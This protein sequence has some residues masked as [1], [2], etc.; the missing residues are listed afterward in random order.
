MSKL[1]ASISVLTALA[2]ITAACTSDGERSG[3]TP[4]S[5][6]PAPVTT[7]TLAVTTTTEA[8]PCEEFVFCVLYEIDPDAAWSDGTPVSAADLQH[9]L[10]MITDPVTGAPDQ[11][12]YRLIEEIVP[13]GDGTVL[14]GFSEVFAP[15]RTLFEFVLPAHAEESFGTEGAPVTGPFVLDEWVEGDRIVLRRNP[16]YWASSDPVSEAPL[17][18]VE[19]IVFVFPESVRDQL[20]GLESG[21]IDVIEPRP[22]EWMIPELESMDDVTYDVVPGEFWEHIDFNHDDP[23]LGQDWVREAISLAIDREEILDA[24]VR[25]IDPDAQPLDSAIWMRNSVNYQ[26]NYD[27]LHDPEAAESLLKERFCELAAD[28]VYECQGRRMSFTWATTV[29]DEYR[30]SIFEIVSNS[31]EQIGIEVVLDQRTPSELFSSNVFFGGPSIWQIISFSWKG[32]ADPFRAN[33]TFF[34]TG[35]APSGFGTLN[36][37]R[38]CNPEVESLIRSTQTLVDPAA[39]HGAYHQADIAYLAD[40]AIVPLF[41]K[42]EL[43]AFNSAL[44]GLIPNISGSTNLWNV[45]AWQGQETVVVAL[46]GEPSSLDPLRPDGDSARVV[47]TAMLHGLLGVDPSLDFVP[48]LVEQAEARLGGAGK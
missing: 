27:Q 35:D 11:V 8:D 21:D 1:R 38:Y 13:L 44:S 30:N 16:A 24:T 25:A 33:S 23:L 48:V 19:E 15:W 45:A 17:G 10:D 3:S 26:D 9:T 12:G 29:G 18:D 7:T 5:P 28:G 41:Q 2:I 39:R 37:N 6:P 42:P 46:D 31:L 43:L 32:E 40:D 36:V 4:I 34:C 20:Q 14:V 22:L 47:L